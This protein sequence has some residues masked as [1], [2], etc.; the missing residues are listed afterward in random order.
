MICALPQQKHIASQNKTQ[1]SADQKAVAH[2]RE[3]VIGLKPYP[4]A[5]LCRNLETGIIVQ[6]ERRMGCR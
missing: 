1:S 5:V 3:Q 2:V 4:T 6:S